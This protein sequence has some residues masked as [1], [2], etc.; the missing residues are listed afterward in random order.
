MKENNNNN[1][2]KMMLRKIMI[3]MKMRMTKFTLE[4]TNIRVQLLSSLQIHLKCHKLFK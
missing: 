1:L 2:I 3:I 4:R